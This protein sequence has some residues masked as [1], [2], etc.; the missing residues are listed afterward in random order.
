MSE[1]RTP[2]PR[3]R[4]D[5]WSFEFPE[6]GHAAF[7]AL[8]DLRTPVDPPGEAGARG[9]WFFRA[10]AGV[11]GIIPQV[12]RVEREGRRVVGIAILHHGDEVTIEDQKA[13]FYEVVRAI[14]PPRSPAPAWICPLCKGRFE[15]GAVVLRCPLCGE[16]YHVECWNSLEGKRCCSR[17]C[18]FAPG[19]VLEG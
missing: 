7:R 19:P 5:Q 6:R 12:V 2:A 1:G 18:R 15:A 13:R 14:L 10:E 16:R 9:V 11:C 3:L 8:P 17:S 4:F